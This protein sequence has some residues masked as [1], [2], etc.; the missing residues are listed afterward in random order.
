MTGTSFCFL[1]FR[2]TFYK[3]RLDSRQYHFALEYGNAVAHENS[4][5]K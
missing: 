3:P 5:A 2:F 4:I 1:N